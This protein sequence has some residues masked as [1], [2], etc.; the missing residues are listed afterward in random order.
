M[1][2]F[3]PLH[4]SNCITPLILKEFPIKFTILN[5]Q[6]EY[7]EQKNP[8]S[9][10]Y[11]SFVIVVLSWVSESNTYY[12]F[13]FFTCQVLISKFGMERQERFWGMSI[14]IN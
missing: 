4:Y 11:T 3:F 6:T 1:N 5:Y 7:L 2:F 10:I 12:I 8:N 14:Q 9:L 13:I